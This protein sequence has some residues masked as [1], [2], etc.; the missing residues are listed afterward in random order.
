MGTHAQLMAAGGHYRE[1]AA[2]QLAVDDDDAVTADAPSHMDRVRDDEAV[3][4]G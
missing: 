3:T 1:V 2:A 4:A